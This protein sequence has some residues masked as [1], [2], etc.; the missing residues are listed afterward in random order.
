MAAKVAQKVVKQYVNVEYKVHDEA[1]SDTPDTTPTIIGLSLIEEGD[2]NDN[3][4]G[5]QIKG[6]SFQMQGSIK[7]DSS[8]PDSIVR[9]IIIQ[10]KHQDGVLPSSS[11]IHTGGITV[12]SLPSD[13]NR[14]R[15]VT[16]YDKRTVVSNSGMGKKIYK[17]YK[18]WKPGKK[19]HYKGIAASQASQ[20]NNNLYLI[21]V[22]DEATNT[23]TVIYKTRL[24]Y[25]DN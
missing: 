17:Y 4:N 9:M 5:R 13:E 10:D 24:K 12:S 3:R 7:I 15:F 8:A 25:I 20:G 16:L 23:P 14:K 6:V 19:I 21:I 2:D 1:S 22:S 18:K 11:D